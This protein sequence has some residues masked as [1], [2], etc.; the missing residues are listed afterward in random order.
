[1]CKFLAW[2]GADLCPHFIIVQFKTF[3]PTLLKLRYLLPDIWKQ[4]PAKI[5]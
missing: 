3:K 4:K 1:M 2:A 5:E